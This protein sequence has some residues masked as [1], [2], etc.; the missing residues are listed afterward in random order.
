M[1]TMTSKGENKMDFMLDM[2]EDR[3]IVNRAMI[4][5]EEETE[6]KTYKFS[7]P[8]LGTFFQ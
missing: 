1:N 5:K 3:K 8:F 7:S 6:P 4:I 2:V